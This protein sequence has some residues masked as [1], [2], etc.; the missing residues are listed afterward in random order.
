MKTDIENTESAAG[1]D[2]SLSAGS[3][4]WIIVITH[5]DDIPLPSV[6]EIT[7]DS[8]VE[9]EPGIMGWA[10]RATGGGMSFIVRYEEL[11]WSI[12]DAE[13]TLRRWLQQR[14]DSMSND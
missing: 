5:D 10:D 4:A 6:L 2:S 13:G 8:G 9:W 14:M 7:L 11:Y 1:A 12:A 3:T